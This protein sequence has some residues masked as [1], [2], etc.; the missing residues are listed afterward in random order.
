MDKKY[1]KFY[2]TK[3]EIRDFRIDDGNL[4]KYD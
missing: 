3:S 2:K 4:E 1:I